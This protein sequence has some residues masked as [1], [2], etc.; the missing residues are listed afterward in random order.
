MRRLSCALLL[1]ALSTSLSA[2][3]LLGE[4]G[5]DGNEG[6]GE[7]DQGP[8]TEGDTVCEA[9]ES[10]GLAEDATLDSLG[11][12]VDLLCIFS[13]LC[14]EEGSP[15]LTCDG[16]L[17]AP[18]FS[19]DGCLAARDQLGI[20][21]SGPCPDAPA[22]EYIRF[23]GAFLGAK[24]CGDLSVASALLNDFKDTCFEN[25]HIPLSCDTTA[26][27]GDVDGVAATCVASFR[28][29]ADGSV[30]NLDCSQST[31]DNFGGCTCIVEDGSS[32]TGLWEAF[33]IDAAGENFCAD[34]TLIPE[35]A[36]EK[37]RWFNE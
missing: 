3:R 12:D 8:C 30:Y 7:G 34:A 2:C 9:Y 5:D 25:G 27:V 22:A 15:E 24:T 17:D 6:E 26:Y 33:E 11:N 29:C 21:G 36:R 19:H 1:L 4:V 28:D 35:M 16:D 13:E 23:I 18:G 32:R 14:P 10:C 31:R 37:C 20:S